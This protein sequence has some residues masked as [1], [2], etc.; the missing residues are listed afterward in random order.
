MFEQLTGD[1][2]RWATL[3]THG[4]ADPSGVDAYVW[5]RL[6]SSFASA[7]V[8]LCNGL[9]A[10]AHGLCVDDVDSA[11]LMTFMACRLIP[12]DKN[13]VFNLSEFVDVP[14]EEKNSKS[15]PSCDWQ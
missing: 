10:V 1:L 9:A 7:F 12:L 6:C 11:E 13:Q 3:P 8:T 15:Y 4:A 2:I 14:H 5:R